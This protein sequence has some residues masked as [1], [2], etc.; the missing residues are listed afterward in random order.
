MCM[1]KHCSLKAN[2]PIAKNTHTHT[3]CN[4][5]VTLMHILAHKH[6]P[7]FTGLDVGVTV[8]DVGVTVSEVGVIVPQA[9]EASSEKMVS[10]RMGSIPTVPSASQS[11][12]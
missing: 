1:H 10:T 4:H 5:K 8:S 3:H 12:T 7:E 11:Y 9:F 6:T 2:V